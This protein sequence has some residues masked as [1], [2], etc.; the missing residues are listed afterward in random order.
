VVTP[1]TGPLAAFIEKTAPTG[2]VL[3]AAFPVQS[4][5]CSTPD[6]DDDGIGYGRDAVEPFEALANLL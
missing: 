4:L 1:R 2:P 6:N 5:Y 3:S